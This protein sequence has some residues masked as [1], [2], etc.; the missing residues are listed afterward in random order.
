MAAH[1]S[2][3][4]IRSKLAD[5]ALP[6]ERQGQLWVGYGSGAPCDGCDRPITPDQVEHE[7]I[8]G[9]RTLRLHLDCLR[10]WESERFGGGEAR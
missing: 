1:P 3:H 6:R 10:I 5:G 2:A 4:C 9:R 8:A 7:V